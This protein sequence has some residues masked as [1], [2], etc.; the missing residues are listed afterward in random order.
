MNRLLPVVIEPKIDIQL[1]TY[2]PPFD[3][4]QSWHMMIMLAAVSVEQFC[5]LIR[6][7]KTL[8]EE[9]VI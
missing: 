1:H 5:K 7:F 9:G 3:L 2:Y 6:E 4:K 8:K